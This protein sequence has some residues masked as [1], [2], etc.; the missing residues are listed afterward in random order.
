M[1]I[2]AHFDGKVL[3]P[4]EP[5]NLREGDKVEL[6]IQAVTKE[7]KREMT[8]SDLANGPW[9]GAWA[10]REDIKDP[11]DFVNEIRRRIDRREL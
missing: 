7:Q 1:T 6:I 5:V 4:D 8:G 3:V 10:D 11:V 2:K 9:V